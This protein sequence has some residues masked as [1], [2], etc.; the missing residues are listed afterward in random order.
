MRMKRAPNEKECR[1][2]GRSHNN[3]SSRS[4]R[5]SG[6]K[7]ARLRQPIMARAKDSR[8]VENKKEKN[9]RPHL[10]HNNFGA[11]T[12]AAPDEKLRS[13]FLVMLSL[14]GRL[15]QTPIRFLLM[16]WRFTE[17]PYNRRM[18][19]KQFGDLNGV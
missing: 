18:L 17:T 4:S 16:V 9:Q 8:K 15:C 5:C 2:L 12:P 3:T 14:V 7:V 10:G 1:L 11:V 6:S 13:R 19:L